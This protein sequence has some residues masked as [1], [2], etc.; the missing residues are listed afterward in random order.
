VNDIRNYYPISATI[1]TSGQPTAEQFATIAEQGYTLVINLAMPDSLFAI[2]NESDI[3]R[4]LGMHYTAIPVPWEA[5]THSDL[6]RF[7]A[8]MQA[9]QDQKIWVHCALNKRVSCFIY[10]Y[11]LCVLQLPETES[12]FPMVDIWQPTGA[13]ESF[14]QAAKRLYC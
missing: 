13:W 11:K 14:I 3:V 4:A 9:H 5:P 8:V 7:F 1:A 2:A 12:Q 6:Q 10:L